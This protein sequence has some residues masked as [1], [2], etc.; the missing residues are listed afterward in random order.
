MAEYKTFVWKYYI[1]YFLFML[2]S[3]FQLFACFLIS[4][5]PS[6]ARVNKKKLMAIHQIKKIGVRLRGSMNYWI[7]LIIFIVS[8]REFCF[9]AFDIHL[10]YLMSNNDRK[11]FGKIKACDLMSRL[12]ILEMIPAATS[13]I[14]CLRNVKIKTWRLLFYFFHLL[15]L[16]TGPSEEFIFE[17]KSF[18]NSINHLVVSTTSV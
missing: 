6:S 12:L 18:G 5:S 15:D 17:Q 10:I 1:H 4:L 2:V 7:L 8:R 14:S 16:L 13:N 9:G 3:Y 11:Y